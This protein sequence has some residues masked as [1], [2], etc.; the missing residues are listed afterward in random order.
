MGGLELDP[1]AA[2]RYD[3]ARAHGIVDRAVCLPLSPRETEVMAEAAER[4]VAAYL[5][6][7]VANKDQAGPDGGKDIWYVGYKLNV[8]W[9]P[10]ERG[11]M[12]MPLD[13]TRAEFYA[14]VTG[15]TIEQFQLRGWAS[16]GMLTETSSIIDLGHGPCFGLA[17]RQLISLAKAIIKTAEELS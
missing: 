6:V 9:T 5:G 7:E 8:K 14:L 2:D 17:Q 12:I 11:H 1:R 4:F 3:Y 16:N 10:R 13:A 15:E